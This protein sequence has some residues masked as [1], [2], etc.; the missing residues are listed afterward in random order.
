M[1]PKA[2]GVIKPLLSEMRYFFALQPPVAVREQLDALACRYANDHMRL[3][4]PENLHVTLAYLGELDGRSLDDVLRV[5]ESLN[6]RP[7]HIEF[8]QLDFWKKPRIYCLTATAPMIM[9]QLA[10]DLQRRSRQLGFPVADRPY[11]PHITLLRKARE[12]LHQTIPTIR[13][14]ADAIC[15]YQSESKN[16]PGP[17]YTVIARWPLKAS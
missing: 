15:L 11:R 17:R 2:P 12:P 7:F 13:W 1:K 16:T 9:L 5:P 6:Y 3:L 10:H 4:P 14:Q 8:S